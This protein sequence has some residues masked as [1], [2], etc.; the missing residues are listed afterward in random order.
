MVAY[1]LRI[2]NSRTFGWS[3]FARAM[4]EG[5][6]GEFWLIAG[7]THEKKVKVNAGRNHRT[8]EG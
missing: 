2:N 6:I 7:V 4:L 5:S 1:E 8:Q 3:Y